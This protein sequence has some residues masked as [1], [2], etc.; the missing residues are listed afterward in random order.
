MMRLLNISKS[1]GGVDALRGVNLELRAGTVHAVSGENGAGKSTMMRIIAGVIR[2]DS[3]EMLFEGVPLNLHNPQQAM[4]LGIFIVHQEPVF[5]PDLS[6]MENVLI[7]REL[8]RSLG[9]IDRRKS[10]LEVGEV[11][12]RVGLPASIIGRQMRYLSPGQRQLVTLARALHCQAKV[13]IL[14]EPTSLLSGNEA[15]AL[16]AAVDKI[17]ASGGGVLYISHRLQEIFQISH[18]VTVLRNGETTLSSPLSA[19]DNDNLIFAMT[20]EKVQHQ[21]YRRRCHGD[22]ILQLDNFSNHEFFH[23]ISLRLQRGEILGLYGLVGAGR[24]ELA[25]AM[26]GKISA[27][28]SLLLHQQRRRF[29]HPRQALNAG[30]V[31][32]PEERRA[33]GLFARASVAA[34]LSAGVLR[35]RA[36]RGPLIDRKQEKSLVSASIRKFAVKAGDLRSKITALSGGNQQKVLF[37]RTLLQQPAVLIL[38]EPSR[39]VDVKTKAEIHRAIIDLAEQQVALLVISSEL[40]EVLELSDRIIVLYRGNMVGELDR[41]EFDEQKILRLA[42]GVESRPVEV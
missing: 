25:Q 39:G 29:R 30:M 6:V 32:L 11:L 35:H 2:P 14:D 13:L 1:F 3:G 28:G 22:Q 18:E 23:N 33:Q 8:T 4:D 12:D 5:F 37:G 17:T 20:G 9:L 7:G 26:I 10:F 21:V 34:N 19:L 24:S 15:Q 31:Y 16:F 41:D 27:G 40:P 38:D 36:S 42:L